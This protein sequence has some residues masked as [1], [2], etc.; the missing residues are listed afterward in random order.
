MT[1]KITEKVSP[2]DLQNDLEKYRQHAIELGA[3]DAKIIVTD[4]IAIDE[5]VRAKCLYPKCAHYGTSANCPPHVMDLDQVRKVVGNYRHAVF[6]RLQTP[7]DRIAGAEARKKR[8]YAGNYNR[9]H[10]IVTKIESEAFYDGYYLALGFAC[11]TCKSVFCRNEPCQA[12]QTGQPCRYPLKARPSMEAVG[13]DVFLMAARVGWD[14]YPVGAT[15]SPEDIAC[16][17]NYGLILIY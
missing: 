6:I 8:L 2:L 4:L 9:T 16:G 17:A 1:R 3:T 5:R 15:T 10:E 7:A 11:G 13:M 14:T 12:L